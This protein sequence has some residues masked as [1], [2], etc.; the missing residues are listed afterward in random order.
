MLAAAC[1]CRGRLAWSLPTQAWRRSLSVDKAGGKSQD[2]Q[3]QSRERQRQLHLERKQRKLQKQQQL[4]QQAKKAQ[5]KKASKKLESTPPGPPV[6]LPQTEFPMRADAARRE[7]NYLARCTTDLYAWQERERPADGPRFVLH[8]GP[9]FANGV[10]HMGHALNKIIKDIVNRYR[11]LRGDRI[12]YVPGWDRHGLPI[13]LK[14][15]QRLPGDSSWSPD[16]VPAVA[17]RSAARQEAEAAIVAQR[18]QFQRWG[19]MGDW[20]RS[21]LTMAPEY[22]AGQLRIFRRM[23]EKGLIYRALRPVHWSPSAMTALAEAELEYNDAHCSRAVYVRFVVEQA[24]AELLQDCPGL[25]LV[26]WTTT[27]WSLVGNQALCVHPDIEYSVVRSSFCSLSARA[28]QVARLHRCNSR[29]GLHLL[30]HVCDTG[31]V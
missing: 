25:S 27:P 6:N 29:P 30:P 24:S 23:V 31:C 11:L 17:V 10:P 20:E 18:E 14:A 22:E 28:S 19:V 15:L 1:R 8:D 13:E 5:Q 16:G 7:L 9:P 26:A 2:P 3:L 4:K 21:Y 12:S